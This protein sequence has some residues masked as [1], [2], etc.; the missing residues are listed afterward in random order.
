MSAPIVDRSSPTLKAIEFVLE[1][2]RA[3]TG[4]PASPDPL[5]ESQPQA[6]A[7]VP[8][9]GIAITE[10]VVGAGED[11]P[12]PARRLAPDPVVSEAPAAP[13]PPLP[14]VPMETAPR[15]W[16]GTESVATTE[17]RENTQVAS[18]RK[19]LVQAPG[20]HVTLEVE[21]GTADS[22][23]IRVS[24]HGGVVRATV[25]SSADLGIRLSDHVDEL[26][27]ALADRGFHE[28]TLTLQRAEPPASGAPL[29]ER[30]SGHPGGR[31]GRNRDDNPYYGP[32][33]K[34]ADDRPRQH[35][36]PEPEEE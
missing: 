14:L 17:T 4:R 36:R 13:P 21:S 7:Q 20:N 2:L 34:S 12:L 6:L 33:Y 8:A 25:L 24:V 3:A 27:R 32:R 10:L 30:E 5:P 28:S 23:R 18:P 19:P 16:A 26:R 11:A 22:A 35:R 31:Q 1:G 15:E 29:P 9:K